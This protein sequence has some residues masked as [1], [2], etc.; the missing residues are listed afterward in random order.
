[1]ETFVFMR[2]KQPTIM[3]ESEIGKRIKAL[4]NEKGL[5][6]EQLAAQTGYTKGYLSKV[7]KSIKAPPVS[8]LG[9]IGRLS[10]EKRGAIIAGEGD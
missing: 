9:T 3:I 1:L 4:R 5:T 10:R 2:R 6:L 8:T 7:E